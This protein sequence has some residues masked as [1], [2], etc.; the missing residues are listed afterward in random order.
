MKKNPHC[1]N[2]TMRKKKH[3]RKTTKLYT[4]GWMEDIRI[5]VSID[6]DFVRVCVCRRR[7]RRHRKGSIRSIQWFSALRQCS[8]ECIKIKIKKR[9]KT[10]SKKIKWNN[11]FSIQWCVPLFGSVPFAF[12]TPLPDVVR[13]P[14]TQNTMSPSITDRLA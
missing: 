12:T 6:L 7:L 14:H 4:Y 8:L 11:M 9:R 1:V 3:P 2:G 5:H 13:T 10:E